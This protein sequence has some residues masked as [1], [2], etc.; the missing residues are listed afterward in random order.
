MTTLDSKVHELGMVE[1]VFTLGT[2]ALYLV[3][4]CLIYFTGEFGSIMA[5]ATV[6]IVGMLVFTIQKVK[7]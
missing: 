7:G 5:I 4:V 3:I 6:A 1:E 2:H